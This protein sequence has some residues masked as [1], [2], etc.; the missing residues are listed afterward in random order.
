MVISRGPNTHGSS[1]LMARPE[2]DVGLK[3]GRN[4][5]GEVV[6]LLEESAGEENCAAGMG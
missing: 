3:G 6:R 4:A 2:V 1:Y 5:G